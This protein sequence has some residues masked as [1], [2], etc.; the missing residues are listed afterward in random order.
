M[1][2]SILVDVEHP[3][4]AVG[5]SGQFFKPG[6]FACRESSVAELDDVNG[7]LSGSAVDFAKCCR[8]QFISAVGEEVDDIRF[9]AQGFNQ[10]GLWSVP[11]DDW[12]RSI[13]ASNIVC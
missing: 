2:V 6:G 1:H 12:M 4:L 3:K 8:G 7:G 9:D 5:L 10:A 13:A 11:S